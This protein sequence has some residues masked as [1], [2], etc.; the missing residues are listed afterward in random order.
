MNTLVG[1]GSASDPT[2][3]SKVRISFYNLKTDDCSDDL[4]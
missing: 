2:K 4:T 1:L 3:I